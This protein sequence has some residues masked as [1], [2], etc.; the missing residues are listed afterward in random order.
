M[1]ENNVF[2][3]DYYLLKVSHLNNYKGRKNFPTEGFWIRPD[4]KL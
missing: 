1:C 3:K 4:S 2:L